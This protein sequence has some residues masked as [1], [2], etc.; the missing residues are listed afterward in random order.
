M[1]F[2]KKKL[3]LIV[4]PVIPTLA[5]LLVVIVASLGISQFTLLGQKKQ[6]AESSVLT[7]STND[8]LSTIGDGTLTEFNYFVIYESGGNYASTGGDGGRAYGAYQFDYAYALQPFL[9]Y[10]YNTNPTKYSM[11]AP[12]LSSSCSRSELYNNSSLAAAWTKAYNLDTEGF[13]DLQDE[14]IYIN[15]Y[16]PIEE[17]HA[18]RGLDLSSRPDVIKGLCTSIHNRKGM[19]TSQYS[20]ITQSGVTNETSDEDFIT[21]LCDAFGTRGGNIYDRYCVDYSSA[22]CGLLCEKNMCLNILNSTTTST[23]TSSVYNNVPYYNQGNYSHVAFNSG[24]VATDGCGITSFSMVASYY[25]GRTITPEETAPW[26]MAN[27]ANTVTSWG[28]FSILAQ[29][30]GFSVS[31]QATGPLWGGSYE[32]IIQALQQGKLVIGSQTGG[33]FNPS[34]SGHYIVYTGITSDGKILVNDP[35]STE[36]TQNSSG[37]SYSEAFGS[38]KQYWIFEWP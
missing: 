8:F 20:Y 26:A 11:F 6:S 23:V 21:M 17:Y 1:K 29:H 7:S 36:R 37:Y 15:T 24:S 5:I 9:E 14:Y 12:Y 30:Y 4:L 32:P 16:L 22:A 38:C 27:G 18:A 3:W 31:V 34:G 28:A 2:L 13:K 10:C 19:E 33:T 25:L 35:G